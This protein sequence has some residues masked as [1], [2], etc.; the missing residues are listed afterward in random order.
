M[1]A[2]L[3]AAG[4]WCSSTGSERLFLGASPEVCIW[5]GVI[6][7]PWEMPPAGAAKVLAEVADF[8]TC[9]ILDQAQQIGAGRREWPADVLLTQ[10]V[11]LAE[12]VSRRT[13]R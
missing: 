8:R 7:E 5:A 10:A 4:N 12:Q 6:V 9:H 3:C 2:S 1:V 11:Q 13:R